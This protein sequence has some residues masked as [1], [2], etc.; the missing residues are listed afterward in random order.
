MSSAAAASRLPLR[1]PRSPRPLSLRGWWHRLSILGTL[2]VL[3]VFPWVTTTGCEG[4]S[5][6]VTWTGYGLLADGLRQKPVL[7]LGPVLLLASAAL[8]AAAARAA[9]REK[10]RFF[11]HLAAALCAVIGVGGTV[12]ALLLPTVADVATPHAAYALGVAA[13]LTFF[14]DA[15]VRCGVGAREWWVVRHKPRRAALRARN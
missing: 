7:W 9:A 5:P 6:P 10:P 4:T 12:V 8:V 13:L 11:A 2:A 1:T 14:A 15:L 3:L